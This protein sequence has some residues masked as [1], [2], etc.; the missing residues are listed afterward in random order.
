MNF[1]IPRFAQL[2]LLHGGT[3]I[4]RNVLHDQTSQIH[5]HTAVVKWPP[6]TDEQLIPAKKT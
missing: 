6:M 1:H 2:L 3:F 5:F 4:T